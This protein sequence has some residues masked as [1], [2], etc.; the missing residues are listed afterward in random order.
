VEG[1]GPGAVVRE[2]EDAA[3]LENLNENSVSTG[4]VVVPDV[5]ERV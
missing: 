1:D 5:C 3:A 4:V 2:G